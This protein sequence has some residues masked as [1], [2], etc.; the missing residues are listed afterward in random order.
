MRLAAAIL[1]T[2]L[3]SSG[4]CARVHAQLAD[5]R[6][7]LTLSGKV[8]AL[9]NETFTLDYGKGMITVA[10][11]D[12][13]W[14]QSLRPLWLHHEITV[15]GR[16]DRNA[17]RGPVLQA[18][19]VYDQSLGTF[20]RN[21]PDDQQDA[22]WSQA[23][24]PPPGY[25]EVTGRVVSIHGRELTL[26]TG[27]KVDTSAMRDNPLDE[28]GYPRVRLGDHIKVG[29]RLRAD[30]FERTELVASWITRIHA[31]KLH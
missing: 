14:Y 18:S 28:Q 13:P 20:F 8:V 9:G 21:A 23:P 25:V 6:D 3:G 17:S 4:V 2:L 22:L 5:A 24:P 12:A 30:L 10:V 7:W 19:A 15:Y 29:G 11:T 26:S 27:V 31:P 16:L 1:L